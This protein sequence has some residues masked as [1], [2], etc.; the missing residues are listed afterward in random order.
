MTAGVG[1]WA[2]PRGGYRQGMTMPDKTTEPYSYQRVRWATVALQRE[3]I[4]LRYLLEPKTPLGG[5][6]GPATAKATTAFQTDQS[7][8]ADGWIGPKTARRLFRQRF[9]TYP[10]PDNLLFGLARLESSMDPGAEG[11]VD[12]R[13]RGLLQY[14]RRWHPEVDD[15]VAFSRPD[16]CIAKAAEELRAAFG[17]YGTW[18]IAIASHNS[19]EKA[20]AWSQTGHAPD[21][22]IADYVALVYAAAALPI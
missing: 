8:V 9:A 16:L 15:E 22:Q 4:W 5:A 18:Q 21:E 1:A 7:L 13:D 6:F 14:N 11:T 3:L 19:P 10:V 20:L 12:D 17:T 2:V